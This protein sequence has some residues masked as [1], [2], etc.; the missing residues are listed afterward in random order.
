MNSLW[1]F[2][3]RQIIYSAIGVLCHGILSWIII[4]FHLPML[5]YINLVILIFF[6]IVFGPWVGLIVGVVGTL[7]GTYGHLELWVLI[8]LNQTSSRLIRFILIPSLLTWM[9]SISNGLTGFITGLFKLKVK[10]YNRRKDIGNAISA[11][12]LGVAA[13][14]L[15]EWLFSISW[16]EWSIMFGLL[17]GILVEPAESIFWLAIFIG[18]FV[19]EHGLEFLREAITVIILLPILLLAYHAIVSRR[20]QQ[21]SSTL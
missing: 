11:G 5:G 8:S 10:Q 19:L 17:R 3:E 15:C 20:E 16:S 9:V 4:T 1:E 21:S 14:I 7:V 12:I 13:G 18:R 2:K 6:G